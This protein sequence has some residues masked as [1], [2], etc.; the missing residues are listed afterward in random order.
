MSWQM[1]DP[2]CHPSVLLV[3][4]GN[5]GASADTVGAGLTSTQCCLQTLTMGPRSRDLPLPSGSMNPVPFSS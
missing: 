5:G 2:E 3:L 1:W 4:P